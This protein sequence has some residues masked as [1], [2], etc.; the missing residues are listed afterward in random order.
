[1]LLVLVL[2]LLL[3]R[4]RLV[5]LLLILARA[6]LGGRAGLGASAGS[7][8]LRESGVSGL[9]AGAHEL[10]LGLGANARRLADGLGLHLG[11]DGGR[12]GGGLG[13]GADFRRGAGGLALGADA[14]RGADSLGLGAD[15]RRGTGGLGLG[16]SLDRLLGFGVVL[17][18]HLGCHGRTVAGLLENLEVDLDAS[19]LTLDRLGVEVPAAVV[20]SGAGVEGSGLIV[21]EEVV[22]DGEAGISFGA[23]VA[24]LLRGG[25]SQDATTV[26]AVVDVW[27]KC[28]R[29][30]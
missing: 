22:L 13:L 27:I 26:L 7:K 3:A 15:A 4:A 19:I 28:Q 29:M 16:A 23:F 17:V 14:R 24:L 25:R 5:V 20:A 21:G 11:V 12:D 1:M 9:S 6:R 2:V 30:C 18:L 8:G 10:G